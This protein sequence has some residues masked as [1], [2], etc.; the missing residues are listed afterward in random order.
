MGEEYNNK[1][2]QRQRP[3]VLFFAT[4]GGYSWGNDLTLSLSLYVSVHPRYTTTYKESA[5]QLHSTTL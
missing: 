3:L 4:R 5:K 2:T 1:D